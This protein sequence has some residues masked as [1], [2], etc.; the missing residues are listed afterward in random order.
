MRSENKIDVSDAT[1][2][3]CF[4]RLHYENDGASIDE[5]IKDLN[6][7]Q[8]L[9]KNKKAMRNY[10]AARLSTIRYRLKR[11]QSKV[12]LPTVKRQT[13]VSPMKNLEDIILSAH[14]RAKAKQEK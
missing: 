11:A 14:A 13:P 12:S 5:V 3:E 4:M 2:I 1:L 10:V 8:S 9:F 6:L 7:D